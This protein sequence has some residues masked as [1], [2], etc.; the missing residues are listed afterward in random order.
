[1]KPLRV[2]LVLAL[3]AVLALTLAPT[4]GA[5]AHKQREPLHPPASARVEKVK[6]ARTSS[7]RPALLVAVRYPIQAAGRRL[8]L[9]VRVQ[10]KPGHRAARPGPSPTG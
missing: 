9:G 8:R 2:T 4:A 3:L 10:M 1:M 5:A 6:V 7:G